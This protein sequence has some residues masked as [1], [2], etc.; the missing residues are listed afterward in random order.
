MF[1]F[2]IWDR[3]ERKLLLGRDR[4]GIKPLYVWRAGGI[5]AFASEPKAFRALPAF[6]PI[7]DPAAIAEYLTFQNILSARTFLKGVA[8]FPP[9]SWAVIDAHVGEVHSTEYWDFSFAEPDGRS[10]DEDL[11]EELHRL[12]SQAV[13]R[14]LVSDVEV[15]SFLSGGLDSGSIVALA[16]RSVPLMKTFT[17]GFELDSVAGEELHFDERAA[18]EAISAFVGTTQFEVIIGPRHVTDCLQRLVHHVEEP[19]V[20]QSYPNF[21]AAE[22]ASKFVKVAFAG[23]GGDEVLGGYPWRYPPLGMA[24]TEFPTW[25]FSVWQRLLSDDQLRDV[26]LPMR[27][28]LAD[29]SSRDVHRRI[30]DSA[31]SSETDPD[32]WL[33]AALYFE[34]K[35]FLP[36]LLAIEDR[37]AMAHGLEVRVP[38]LDNDLVD[39]CQRLPRSVRLSGEASVPMSPVGADRKSGGKRILRQAMQGEL[40]PEILAASKQGFAAPDTLWFSRNLRDDVLSLVRRINKSVADPEIAETILGEAWASPAGARH[41]SWSLTAVSLLLRDYWPDDESTIGRGMA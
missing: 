34:A 29:F 20:G 40:P 13:E 19:R 7:L 30:L 17:V 9:A 2:A 36:G 1:A 38:F 15:G 11:A 5:V 26:L 18:A 3:R 31:P 24:G 8:V 35:T 39:F 27:D 37:L 4:Y 10:S 28:H 22:L 6:V 32:D 25:H 41:L 16:V 23:T 12:L 14:Q 21:Y 33:S